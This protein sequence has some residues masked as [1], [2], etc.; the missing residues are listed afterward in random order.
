MAIYSYRDLEV[1]QVWIEFSQALHYL[2]ESQS[3]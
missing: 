1:Y 3:K 2:D